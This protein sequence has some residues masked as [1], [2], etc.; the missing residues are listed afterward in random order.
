MSKIAVIIDKDYEDSELTVPVEALREN[1][2]EV[3]LLG[4]EKGKKLAGKKG[5]AKVTTDGAVKDADA[6]EFDALLIPGGFSPD[7]LRIHEDA[8]RFVKEFDHA[9][10]PIAAVCH[11]PQLLIE[12]G[13]VRGRRMTSWPSVRTDLLNAGARWEDA[14][15]VEDGNLITSRKPGDLEDFSGALLKRLEGGRQSRAAG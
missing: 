14:S 15:V 2:H 11:G 8:V 10:K 6:R 4:I 13:V 5:E 9:G 12:A 7:H 1:G 3:V